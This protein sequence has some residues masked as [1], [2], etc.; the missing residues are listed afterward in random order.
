MAAEEKEG[1][2]PAR[3]E[4]EGNP[5]D[6]LFVKEGRQRSVDVLGIALEI[7]FPARLEEGPQFLE[8][9]REE[10]RGEDRGG[11]PTEVDAQEAPFL[12]FEGSEVLAEP[13]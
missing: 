13:P 9:G 4:A 11:S 5:I 10:F 12:P 3:L 8:K 2:T 1:A 7:E 6:P